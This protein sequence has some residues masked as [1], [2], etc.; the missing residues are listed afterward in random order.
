MKAAWFVIAIM[1]LSGCFLMGQTNANCVA[2][3]YKV[4][5]L[6]LRPS[7][8][9][10]ARQ[11]AGTTSGHRAALWTEQSGLRELP[12]PEGF[13]NSEAAAVNNSGHVAGVVY[14]RVFSHHRAFTFA[15]DALTLLPGEQSRAYN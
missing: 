7:H 5:A 11:V 3:R 10:E 8:V 9:N 4:V 12:L 13:Y 1:A 15:N 14:D 2:D 6:P